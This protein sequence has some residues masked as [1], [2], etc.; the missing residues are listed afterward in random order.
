[1]PHGLR[2]MLLKDIFLREVKEITK[3][4]NAFFCLSVCSFMWSLMAEV[5]T[6]MECRDAGTII[7]LIMH[8]SD[9]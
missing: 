2:E 1:M 3:L 4:Q 6:M 5:Q 8:D 7:I 9:A